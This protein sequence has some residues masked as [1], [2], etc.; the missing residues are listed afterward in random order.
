MKK[1]LLSLASLLLLAV[2]MQALTVTATV[3]AQAKEC[4]IAGNFN[5]WSPS[6]TPMTSVNETT[7]TVDLDV[8]SITND[9]LDFKICAGNAWAYEQLDPSTNFIYKISTNPTVNVTVVTFKAY[10]T[11]SEDLKIEVLVPTDVIECYIVGG[12]N[13]WA[14]PNEATK[15]TL[16]ETTVDGDVFQITINTEAATLEYKFCAGPSWD[17]EQTDATNFKYSVDG[18]SV[19]VNSFKKIFDP[20]K[21]G[22][23]V[24]TAT[25]P[26]GTAE[27]FLIGSNGGWSMDK[28]VVGVKNLDNTFTF[29]VQNTEGFEYRLYNQLDWSHPEVDE[30]GADRP[31]RK[32]AYPADANTSITVYAWKE[33]VTAIDGVSAFDFKV[34]T[35]GQTI[36]VEGVDN[37][38]KV[39]DLMGRL[40]Q[41]VQ[42]TGTFI[43]DK[44]KT[45]IYIIQVDGVAQKV[46]VN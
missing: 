43:S 5:G 44:L 19:A 29:T 21:T 34:Y 27:A 1:I 10:P 6:A 32:V 14:G 15:M 13:N 28:G 7:F 8:S 46:L 22:T 24:I 2:P 35:A 39:F 33:N 17:Y 26:E 45:G 12:F 4:F 36:Q 37:Q 20:S 25:V 11:A 42:T 31:N 9:T 3:P 18:G 30:L 23:I 38:V 40:I 16:S 41:A